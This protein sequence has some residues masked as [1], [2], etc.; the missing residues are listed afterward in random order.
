[1]TTT[2]KTFRILEKR[3]MEILKFVR[4]LLLK[5]KKKNQNNHHTL[6]YLTPFQRVIWINTHTGVLEDNINKL[7]T[8][9]NVAKNLKQKKEI[10]ENS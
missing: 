6:T 7:D 9:W 4:W 8:N 5:F 10:Y 2:D 3:R 1:M